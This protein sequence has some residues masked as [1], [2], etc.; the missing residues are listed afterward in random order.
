MAKRVT[1]EDVKAILDNTGLSTT[2]IST[3]ITSAN[4]FVDATLLDKGLSDSVLKEIERWLTAHMI[5]STRERQSKEE[6]AGGAYIKYA[7]EWGKGLNLTTYGQMAVSL[8]TS[9][10]LSAMAD[11]K[12]SAW[13]KA[14]PQFE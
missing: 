7:G 6:G 2:I 12:K 4:V 10:T 1:P 11:G 8:D 13:T 9:N 3:F 5:V 14:I